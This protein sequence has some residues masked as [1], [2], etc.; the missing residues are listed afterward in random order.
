MNEQLQSILSANRTQQRRAAELN[1]RAAKTLFRIFTRE[2]LVSAITMALNGARC[3]AEINDPTVL[4]LPPLNEEKVRAVLALCPDTITVCGREAAVEYRAPY[5]GTP[6]PPRVNIDF[7]GEHAKDWLKIPDEGILLPDGREVSIYSAVEGY[8][9]YIEAS[10]SQFKAKTRECLNQGLWESWRKPELPVPTDSILPIVEVEYG[11]CAMTEVPLIAFGTVNHDSYSGSW[12]SYWSRDRAEMEKVYVQTCAKFVEVKERVARDM[13][14]KRVGELYSA[15]YYNRELSEEIRARLYNICYGHSSGAITVSEITAFI[16]EVEVAV[17]AI[18]KRKAEV[19]ARKCEAEARREAVNEA[20]CGIGYP[21]AHIWVPESG[22]VAYVLAGKTS[23]VGNFIVLPSA[24]DA[25]YD[26]PYC[27]GDSKCRNWVPFKYGVRSK[28]QD[29]SGRGSLQSEVKLYLSAGVL[30]SGVYGVAEDS[31]GQY[32]FPV[33]Y[34][35]RDGQEMI[36]EVAD[37]KKIR[38]PKQSET[39]VQGTGKSA[40]ANKLA[41][42]MAKFGQQ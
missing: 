9:Y 23:K 36:P 29:F 24:G 3:V 11:R 22:D 26:G 10:S 38:V 39:T 33:V 25:V 6:L 15:H 27:F 34:H 30:Q 42:L 21:E 41:E 13:L 40:S 12:K 35:A 17:V 16:A 1:A 32:F 18:E 5:Y 31:K 20:L 19:E 8:G 28:A 2:E 7:R 4:A 14:K 37:V